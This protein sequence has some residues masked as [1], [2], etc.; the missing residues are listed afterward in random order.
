V[1]SPLPGVVTQVHVVPGV[2]IAA[3][4]RLVTLLAMKLQHDVTS[5]ASGTVAAVHATPGREVQSGETLVEIAPPG[6]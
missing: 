3:G 1:R 4:T 2:V 5:A 6:D